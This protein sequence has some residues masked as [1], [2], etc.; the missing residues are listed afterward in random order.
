LVIY[1]KNING[2]LLDGVL[3][4]QGVFEERR[5]QNV[6]KSVLKRGG[7][8][9]KRGSKTAAFAWLKVR[10]ILQL[11]FFEEMRTPYVGGDHFVVGVPASPWASRWSAWRFIPRR[12]TG[13][14]TRRSLHITK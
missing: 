4:L 13:A 8:R 3:V 14:S 10:Q 12:P 5:V 9:G 6:V 7:M 1:G 11:Y 2:G